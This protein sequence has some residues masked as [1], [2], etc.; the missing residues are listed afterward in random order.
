MRMRGNVLADGTQKS[1]N[2]SQSFEKK[3]KK[4]LNIQHLT[5]AKCSNVQIFKP[6]E[7]VPQKAASS[8]A[9]ITSR[10]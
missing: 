6:F 4:T 8:G 1:P 9:S 3:K 2:N 7:S 5:V 10:F